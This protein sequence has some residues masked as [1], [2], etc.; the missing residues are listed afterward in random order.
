[1]IDRTIR[2][3]FPLGLRNEVQIIVTPLSVDLENPVDIPAIIGASAS[4]VISDIPFA[5]P[6]GATRIGFLDDDYVVNPTYEQIEKGSLDLVVVGSQEGVIMI[7][8]G[9]NE[10][11]EETVLEGIMLAQEVNVELIDLQTQMVNTVGKPKIEIPT[12]S[13]K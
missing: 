3:L 13:E 10:L 2:P 7:E 6:I 5:G 8:A 12:N 4:L 9:A 11:P 1:M